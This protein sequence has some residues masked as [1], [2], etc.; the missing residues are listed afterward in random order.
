MFFRGNGRWKNKIVVSLA[1]SACITV[2]TL[3]KAL[4]KGANTTNTKG[5]QQQ[6]AEV[7][8]SN[9]YR[10]ICRYEKKDDR[11]AKE[12]LGEKSNE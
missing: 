2:R 8:L 10:T 4:G 5:T 11:K 12:I 6:S 3:L 7:E 9:H 1:Y